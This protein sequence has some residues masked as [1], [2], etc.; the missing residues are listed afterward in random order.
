MGFLKLFDAVAEKIILDAMDNG[1]FDD[2]PGK[3][4]PFEFEDDSMVPADL[5][6]GFKI[7]KNSGHLPPEIEQEREIR[8]VKDLLADCKDEQERYRQIQKLNYMVLK[9]NLTRKKPI[10]LEKS[11]YYDKVVER[12]RIEPAKAPDAGPV[13]PAADCGRSSFETQGLINGPGA[14]MPPERTKLGFRSLGS[15]FRRAWNRIYP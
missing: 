12:T 9:L 7:L 11:Q 8:N 2:L 15:W 14:A 4:R 3:G 10:Y 5:K 13:A 6:M 1:E